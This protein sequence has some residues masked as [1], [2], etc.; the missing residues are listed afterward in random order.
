M[1]ALGFEYPDY[2][3]LG[4]EAEGLKRKRVVSMLKKQVQRSVE[5]DKKRRL[6]KNLNLAPEPSAPKKR[7]FMPSS[8]GEEERPSL[9]KY[10]A[11]TPSATSIG[12]TD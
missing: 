9:P 1:D 3:R 5:K 4:E 7:K 6:T 11:E 2:E 10:S 8:R 12:V